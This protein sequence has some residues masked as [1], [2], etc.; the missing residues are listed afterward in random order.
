MV[1]SMIYLP[2][3]GNLFKRSDN[4]V[5]CLNTLI[6]RIWGNLHLAF[7]EQEKRGVIRWVTPAPDLQNQLPN[8]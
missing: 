1:I 7:P 8:T 4:L 2:K 3:L 6:L 5:I